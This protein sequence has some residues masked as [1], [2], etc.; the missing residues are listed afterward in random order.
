MKDPK[1]TLNS[2][3]EAAVAPTQAQHTVKDAKGRVITMKKPHV[4]MQ[5]NL[6]KM[7]GET[8]RNA[9]Y[10]QMVIPLLFVIDIDGDAV[11]F[12]NSQREL[13][14]LITRLDD[15]GITA[16][17]DGIAEHFSPKESQ[18]SDLKNS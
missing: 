16:V 17:M 18:E 7:L 4:L 8:A 9:A 11:A 12:P 1:L 14:A 5:Y 13:D 10:M 2:A 6:V 15:H 3:S